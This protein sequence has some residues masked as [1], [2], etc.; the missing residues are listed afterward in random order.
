MAS[1][2]WAP[3]AEGLAT[4]ASLFHEYSQPS[5]NQVEIY[6]RLQ[7]CSA[8][9]DFNNYLAFLLSQAA[10]RRRRG[11]APRILQRSPRHPG[12]AA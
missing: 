10:V 3:N 1:A 12:Q 6:G 11:P 8:V 4:I 2:P 9:P 7:Q 5:A